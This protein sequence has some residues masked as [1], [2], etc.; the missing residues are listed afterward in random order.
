VSV[1]AKLP[2]NNM[3]KTRRVEP[4]LVILRGKS[5]KKTGCETLRK[6]RS[7]RRMYGVSSSAEKMS[8]NGDVKIVLTCEG[9]M[10]NDSRMTMSADALKNSGLEIPLKIPAANERSTGNAAM[11]SV[12]SFRGHASDS[13][14]NGSSV[15]SSV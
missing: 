4:R 3:R 10:R 1:L 12:S 11:L 2:E 6:L 7:Q 9:V 14:K 5:L 15:K 13:E 8:E